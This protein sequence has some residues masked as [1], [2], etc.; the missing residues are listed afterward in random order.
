MTNHVIGKRLE[1]ANKV[2][3]GSSI[4]NLIGTSRV[5]DSYASQVGTSLVRICFSCWPSFG[6][7]RRGMISEAKAPSGDVVPWLHT[8]NARAGC[9]FGWSTGA[10]ETPARTQYGAMYVSIGRSSPGQG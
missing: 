6:R 2:G 7:R 10:L 5:R 9:W 8:E 3:I 4:K 1:K